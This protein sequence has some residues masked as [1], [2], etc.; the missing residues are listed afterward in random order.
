MVGQ[1]RRCL[2]TLFLGLFGLATAGPAAEPGA[3]ASPKTPNI[4]LLTL[5]TTRADHLGAWGWAHASTPA[6]DALAARGTRFSRC[7]S[8]APITLPSHATILTGQYPPRHGVRDNGTFALAADAETVAERLAARGYDSAAVI[9]AVVLARRHGLD[10]GF[11]VYDDDLGQGYSAGTEVQERPADATTIAALARLSDLKAPFF[12]WVHYY[13]PHEEYRPPTRFADAARGPHRL[14]DGEIS[15]MDEEIGRLLVALPRETVVAV[16]GDH[17]EMLGEHG[18]RAHGLLPFA[19]A[20][21]VPL[22]LAG[23]GVPIGQVSRCLARTADLAPTL[24]ALAG[25]DPL[26]DAD[27]ESLLPLDAAAGCDRVSYSESFLPYYAYKWYPLRTLSDGRALF[28]DAPTPGFFRL[29]IDPGESRDLAASEPGLTKLWSERLGRLR[30]DWG[31]AAGRASSPTTALDREQLEKLASLGYL[32]GGGGGV[33]SPGLP[34]PRSRVGVAARL[35]SAA[36]AVRQGRCFEV[37]RDLEG[38]VKE[39]PHNFPALSLAGQCLRDAGRDRDALALFERAARE[40]PASAVPVANVAGCR[41]RLGE[42][43]EA[44]REFRRALVLDPTQGESAANL[45][46]LLRERG[47][48]SEAFAVLDGAIAAG[49]LDPMLYLERGTARASAGRLE[50]A[51]ADFREAA[52][53]APT[54]VV[55]LENV[56]RA[57]FQLGRLLEAAIAYESLARLSPDR[58]DVWKTLTALYLELGDAAGV[59]RTAREALRLENDPGERA[60]LEALLAP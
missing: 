18:E 13:D 28:L 56:G 48:A 30:R 7:D 16:V 22:M 53:R 34:D 20:R 37:L 46:R 9:S 55:A 38:I 60:K 21:R 24:L 57:T 1:H 50:A 33:I 59:D 15:F 5:D 49:G 3:A 52:R 54:D 35:D 39:D 2:E 41:L 32:A 31:E 10:Q 23:P 58:G 40:N 36:T 6:L 26:A 11:R 51:L 14:Y 43:N 29:D 47:D 19:A 44:E 27:G 25:V 42:K 12:L 17:G 45:A 4:V 8:A